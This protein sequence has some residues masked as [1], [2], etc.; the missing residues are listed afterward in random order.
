MLELEDVNP[1]ETNYNISGEQESAMF[2]SEFFKV[3]N[4]C[5]AAV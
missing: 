4:D 2:C 1:F 5:P 3:N